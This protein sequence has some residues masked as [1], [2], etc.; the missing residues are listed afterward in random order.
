MNCE[1]TYMKDYYAKVTAVFSLKRD[2][3]DDPEVW[4]IVVQKTNT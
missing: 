1:I 2:R 4:D 3:E